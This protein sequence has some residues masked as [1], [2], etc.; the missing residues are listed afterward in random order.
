VIKGKEM[1]IKSETE[2]H[3]TIE[4]FVVVFDICSSSKILE[5]L[6]NNGQLKEWKW[7]WEKI[8]KYIK[9]ESNNGEKYI[10][11]KFVGDGFIILFNPIFVDDI[12]EFCFDLAKIVNILIDKIIENYINVELER[13]G[14][15]IGIDYGELIQV[16]IDDKDEYTGK[17]INIASRLQSTLKEKNHANKMLLSKNVKNKICKNYQNALYIERKR[18]LHNLFNDKPFYC[19][20]INLDDNLKSFVLSK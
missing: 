5:D 19:F 7:F 4:R 11:Y 8:N 17:A 18:E 14:I 10:V 1:I 6:Q 9:D 12:L 13:K 15:T 20:E 2:Y 3:M 16:R